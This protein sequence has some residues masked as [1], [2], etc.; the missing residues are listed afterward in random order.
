MISYILYNTISICSP[1]DTLFLQHSYVVLYTPYLRAGLSTSA[2]PVKGPLT[3]PERLWIP[4]LALSRLQFAIFPSSALSRITAPYRGLFRTFSKRY[5]VQYAWVPL[6]PPAWH[7]ATFL[8]SHSAR[9]LCTLY[10]AY[11][12]FCTACAFL[13]IPHFRSAQNIERSACRTARYFAIS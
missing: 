8:Y 9:I 6:T 13:I 1:H 5:G 3:S 7:A 10:F 12:L 11:C 2:N 4:R